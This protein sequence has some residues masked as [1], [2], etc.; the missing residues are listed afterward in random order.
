[1]QLDV[2]FLLSSA[3]L[4]FCTIVSGYGWIDVFACIHTYIHDS[5]YSLLVIIAVN[6]EHANY[7]TLCVLEKNLSLRTEKEEPVRSSYCM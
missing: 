3:I 2:F 4:L 7:H 1:M 6:N 5:I